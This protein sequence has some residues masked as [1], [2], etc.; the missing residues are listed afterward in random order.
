VE[1]ATPPPVFIVDCPHCKAKVGAQENARVQHQEWN[2]HAMEPFGERILVG[3]CPSC[4]TLIVGRSE[5]TSFEGFEGDEEDHFADVVRVY[6]H[7][8][9]V[10]SSYR[11]PRVALD[12]LSEADKALQAGAHLATCVMLGRALEAI[13]RDILQPKSDAKSGQAAKQKHIMLGAGIKQLKEKKFIDDRLYD[14]SQQLQGFRN[15]SA[16]PDEDFSV[17][18][19]DAEDLQA[20]V[21]AI[22]EY[23]YD[24][25]DR[26]EQ[27]K[28]RLE[29][30]VKRTPPPGFFP[31]L[32]PM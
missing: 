5:Q 15:L 31:T 6:P 26:Y 11:I 21:Y 14:W 20:F 22:T 28:K 18:R 12:S 4:K 24:L 10:F 8:P 19:A 9:K 29:K 13:C 1:N 30:P 3:T 17:S 7:P 2:V 27:F 16:H 32:Q 23:I 25:T